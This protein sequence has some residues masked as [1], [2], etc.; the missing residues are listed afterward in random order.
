VPGREY[1][2]KKCFGDL[3]LG[4]LGKSGHNMGSTSKGQVAWL[5]EIWVT[6]AEGTGVPQKE[7][8]GGVSFG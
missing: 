7:G 2:S 4:T 8:I 1:F 3:R 6:P 5:Q